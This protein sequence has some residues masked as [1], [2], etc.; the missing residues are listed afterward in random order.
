MIPQVRTAGIHDGKLQ[1]A[2]A[3]A[4]KVAGYIN[5]TIPGANAQVV[6]NI[7]GPLYEGHWVL[8][9]ESLAA[10]EQ[11]W[12]RLEADAGMQRLLMEGR[13][14]GWFIGSSIVDRLYETGAEW[15][16]GGSCGDTGGNDDTPLVRFSLS[17]ACIVTGKQC[18]EKL[19]SRVQCRRLEPCK[20]VRQVSQLLDGGVFHHPQGS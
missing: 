9:A 10:H 13:Q 6:R 20:R 5:Q 14:Q 4:T 12:K 8:S 2:F 19:C 16:S 18:L 15:R 1:D 7:G 17:L 3:W 11:R